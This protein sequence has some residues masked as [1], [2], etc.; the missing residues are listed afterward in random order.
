GRPVVPLQWRPAGPARPN[1]STSVSNSLKSAAAP[2]PG[3]LAR[4]VAEFV[5]AVELVVH[6]NA[7]RFG[8]DVSPQPRVIDVPADLPRD[9]PRGEAVWDYAVQK[10]RMLARALSADGLD[11]TAV[12]LFADQLESRVYPER[13]APRWSALRLTLEG[14]LVRP[15]ERL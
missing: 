4:C 15:L 7:W 3:D 6:W 1:W 5:R 9:R 14:L 11:A 13:A 2:S 12:A 10:G 8:I